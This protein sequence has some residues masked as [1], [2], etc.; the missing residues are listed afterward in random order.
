MS[1]N[2]GRLFYLAGVLCLC[3]CAGCRDGG[4]APGSIALV[5][6]SK[7]GTRI[8]SVTRVAMPAPVPVEGFGLVV[9]LAGTGSSDCPTAV[10]EYLKRYVTMQF[11]T[12]GYDF[13]KL[14]DSKDT[15]V[16]RLEA[17]LPAAALQNE[18]FDARVSLLPGSG[19][20]SLHGGWL[21]K[22]ELMPAGKVGAAVRSLATVEG[23]VFINLIGVSKPDLRAGYILGGGRV[24][25]DYRGVLSL[26]KTNY[27]LTSTIRNRLNERYG[28]GTAEALSPNAIGFR[29]PARYRQQKL[30]FVSMVGATYL[31]QTSE[32]IDARANSLV[33]RL[34]MSDRKAE[35]EVALEALGRES[36][37]KLAGL[38]NASDEE[39]RLR[40]ARCML[41]LDDDRGFGTLREIALDPK[42][43]RRLEA[44]DALVV[45]AERNDA[46]AL[47]QRLLRDRDPAIVLAAYERLR[48]MND[49]AIMQERVGR[50]F[51][52]EYVVPTDHQAI[53]VARS[54][55]PR[56]VLFGAPLELRKDLFVESSDGMVMVNAKPGQEYVSLIRRR[57]ARPGLVGQ[58]PCR[59][60]LAEIIRTLGTEPRQTEDGRPAGLG[61]SYSDIIVLVQQLATKGMVT[62]EFWAGDLPKPGK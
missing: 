30:R 54:G 52:I 38:L 23:P 45:R 21:F 35:C 5:P 62:A 43:P 7:L 26:R 33:H 29:L 47:A 60:D 61:V 46:A 55:D 3:L 34:A 18:R 2:Y 53:Y 4:N 49:P 51:Y 17:T 37:S 58:V 48:E 13:D 19:A 32:L 9:G 15:A 6:E 14:I 22:A 16:V 12:G 44:L 20:T 25:A 50:S 24:A 42:S 39:V 11:P 57:S 31:E 59:F 8:S 10:R 56:I 36:L 40:A 41:N 28:P 1:A 27:L